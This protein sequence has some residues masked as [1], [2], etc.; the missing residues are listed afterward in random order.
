MPYLSRHL[1]TTNDS[2]ERAGRSVHGTL[3]VVEL[4]FHQK[5]SH[6]VLHEISH[7][8]RRRMC[9]VGSTECIVDEYGCQSSKLG[10]RKRGCWDKGGNQSDVQKKCSR[11]GHVRT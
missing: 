5:P 2:H 11:G 3:E 4:L 6:G 1:S 7:A 9:A 8:D 10:K